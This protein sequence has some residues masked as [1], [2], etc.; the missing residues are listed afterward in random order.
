MEGVADDL[1]PQQREELAAAIYENRDLFS[2]GPTDM[3][4]TGLVK[5]TIDTGDQRPIRLPPRRLPITK[6]EIEKEEVQKMLDR[7]VIEPCQS[8]WGSPVVLVTKTDGT[9]RLCIDYR[10][11]NDVTRKDPYPLPRI[12]DT[13]DALR[14]LQ[15]FSA[16]DLYSGYWQVEM[17]KQDIDK[18]A[19][20]TRHG[21]FRFTVTPFGLC[22]APATFERLMELI[23]KVLNWKV[24][25]I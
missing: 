5:H 12:D 24:C 2:S 10:K 16:L 25:L 7:G 13:L 15:Y 9:P 1:T 14:G 17:D 23:L 20:V 21:L 19:F 8:S 18:M 3:G 11:L 6:Q 22:N 4:R